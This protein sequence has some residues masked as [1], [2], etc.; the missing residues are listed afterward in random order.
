[1]LVLCLV[2]YV[3]YVLCLV[4]YVVFVLFLVLYVVFVLFLVLYVVFVIGL[5][6]PYCLYFLKRLWTFNL[7]KLK[8]NSHRHR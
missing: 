2:P 7:T 4:L 5:S 3:V 6:I 8:C 1:M